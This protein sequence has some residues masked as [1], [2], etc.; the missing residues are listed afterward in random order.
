L[1]GVQNGLQFHGLHNVALNLHFAL[2]KG[3]VGLEFAGADVDEVGV[4]KRMD[5]VLWVGKFG[6]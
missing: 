5:L 1:T 2:H 3:L 4:W 6:V